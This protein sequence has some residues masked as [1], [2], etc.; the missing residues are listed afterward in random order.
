ME[1]VSEVNENHEAFPFH[2]RSCYHKV[3]FVAREDWLERWNPQRYGW[4]M[5]VKVYWTKADEN[6]WRKIVVFENLETVLYY[7]LSYA[8]KDYI[9]SYSFFY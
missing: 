6:V 5:Y 2:S 3:K 7:L 4:E 8:C 9:I 1:A